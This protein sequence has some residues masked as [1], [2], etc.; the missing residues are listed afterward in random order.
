MLTLSEVVEYVV[1][2]VKLGVKWR[3]SAA[4][5]NN[6]G[7]TFSLIW[8][9]TSCLALAAAVQQTTQNGAAA[10]RVG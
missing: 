3:K 5:V 9:F 2:S 1:W 4:A 6:N 8:V 10:A 7:Q